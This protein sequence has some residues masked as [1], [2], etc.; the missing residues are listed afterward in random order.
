MPENDTPLI[1]NSAAQGIIDYNRILGDY[2][3]LQKKLIE[4][5]TELAIITVELENLTNQPE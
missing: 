4:K 1:D 3:D 5:V 2:I